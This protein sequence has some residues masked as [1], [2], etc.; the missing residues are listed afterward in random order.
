MPTPDPSATAVISRTV[1]TDVEL[2]EDVELCTR[3]IELALR[4]LA[5]V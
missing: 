2:P 3:T 1:R 5:A 4:R